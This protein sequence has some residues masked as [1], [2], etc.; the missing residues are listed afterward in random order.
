M[1][2]IVVTKLSSQLLIYVKQIFLP[3]V[4]IKMEIEIEWMMDRT[5]FQEQVIIFVFLINYI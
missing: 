5:H 3:L 4:F 1:S 2:D